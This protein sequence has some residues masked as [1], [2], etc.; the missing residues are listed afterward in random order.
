MRHLPN[1]ITALRGVSVVPLAVLLALDDY[2]SALVIAIIAGL[3]DLLDGW[4]AK[5]YGWSSALGAWLDPIADK[6]FVLIALTMLALNGLLPMWLVAVVLVRDLLIIAG[7]VAYHW[8]VAPLLVQPR[9]L[10]KFNTV[11]EIVLLVAV[12]AKAALLPMPEAVVVTMVVLVAVVT[13]VSG[14]DYVWVWAQKAYREK[15]LRSE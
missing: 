9:L 11:L 14:I 6:L 5:R 8:L 12:L 7:A 15:W 10:S 13:V 4:L 1:A 3:S 2:R